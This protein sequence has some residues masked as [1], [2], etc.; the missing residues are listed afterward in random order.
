MEQ[1]T[2]IVKAEDTVA[3]TLTKPEVD[4][5]TQF[6]STVELNGI[7]V[8]VKSLVTFLQKINTPLAEG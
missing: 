3:A 1:D 6:M 4:F 8:D 2:K 7:K 5:I